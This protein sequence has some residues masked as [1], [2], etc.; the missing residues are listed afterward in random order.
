MYYKTVEC[1]I[2]LLLL[3]YK[4]TVN[5]SIC[6]LYLVHVLQSLEYLSYYNIHLSIY[7]RI[8]KIFHSMSLKWVLENS[9]NLL[10]LALYKTAA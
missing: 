9:A 1:S 7:Y 4:I 6:I 10:Q 5:H 8:Q 3:G 2:H